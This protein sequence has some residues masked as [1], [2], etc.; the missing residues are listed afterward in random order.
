MGGWNLPRTREPPRG[1][2]R[3]LTFTNPESRQMLESGDRDGQGWGSPEADARA[4][5]SAEATRRLA[6]CARAR[7]LN[8][9]ASRKCCSR[10]DAWS[11]G[12]GNLM[13]WSAA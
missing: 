4:I 5:S 8:T 7:S 1:I 2:P 10:I 3:K 6:R 9:F 12:A 11:S 13:E